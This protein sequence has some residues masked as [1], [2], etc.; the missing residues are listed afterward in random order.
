MA[1]KS[2]DARALT[3]STVGDGAGF[4][5]NFCEYVR[6]GYQ[7]LYVPTSEE[8]RVE[9]EIVAGTSRDLSNAGNTTYIVAWD[10]FEGITPLGATSLKND[11]L[12]ALAG[13]CRSAEEL[14]RLLADPAAKIPSQCVFI[15]R[16]LDDSFNA[17]PTIR[18]GIRSLCEGNRLVNNNARHTV[19]IISPASDIHPK[20][21][22]AMTVVDFSLP[23][24]QT[25][26]EIFGF[27]QDGI[28]SK[29]STKSQCSPDLRE[30]I[31]SNLLGLTGTEA[32]NTLALCI[33]RHNGFCEEM[34][35]TI[36]NEKANIIKK[37]EVLTYLPEADAAS[38]NE[39]GG[40]ENVIEFVDR[41]SKAYT[42]H[43]REHRLDFPKGIV[44]LGI[45][46]TGK[47]M[48]AQAIG[49]QMGL[50]VYM[51]DVGAVFGSLVGESESRMRNAIRQ[52]SAQQGCVLL[53]DEADKAWGGAHQSSGDSGVTQR[54]FGQ[55]LT[56]LAAKKDR[57]FVVMTMN[58][59]KNVPTEFLRMGR[60]DKIFYTEIPREDE[61]RQI[62]EIHLRKRGVDLTG[63]MSESEWADVVKRSDQ[64]VGS[65][66]E[67]LVKEA[68]CLAYMRFC[69]K[70]D[71]GENP[72]DAS[73]AI[74]TYEDFVAATSS[75]VPLSTMQAEEL[76]VMQQFCQNAG[77]PASRTVVRNVP[78]R[79]TRSVS[80]S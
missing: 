33:V 39:I 51:M 43:A 76:Q 25:L 6:A 31:V 11:Q 64:Y 75:I 19:V 2:S 7:A 5:A 45:P 27:V 9:A 67:E 18:R 44:L 17:M 34:L 12:K 42:R 62:I 14:L 65:E 35:G 74:P 15:L 59:L 3:L 58:R 77:T 29:D 24:E 52:I 72:D 28:T 38:R 53:I 1:A 73:A 46:G 47:S 13:K 23:N 30:K 55:L 50:P 22:S 49:K 63:L 68:R 16:D 57:T 41:R 70:R 10:T 79:R 36:K 48:V 56:W 20:L 26:D 61:R 40:F 71:A 80:T 4:R 37:S 66:L 54:V 69:E 78:T 8:N 60:F 21:R 32:E